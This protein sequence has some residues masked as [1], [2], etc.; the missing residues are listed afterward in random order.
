[1]KA[2]R[3]WRA[4]AGAGL[5]AAGM[6]LVL[7]MPREETHTFRVDAGGCRL[8]TDIVEPA[9]GTPRGYVVLYH[10]LSANKRIMS[11]WT[12]GFA[13][14][15]LRVFVPDLPGHGRMDGPF[16]FAWADEC[17]A[18]LLRELIAR[19]L[20]DP[21]KTILAGHSMGGAIALRV[22]ER[23][24]VAGV[25]AISPAPMRPE[26][27]IPAEAIPYH[28][29]GRLPAHSLLL[30]G[31]WETAWMETAAKDLIAS[32]DDGSS[33]YLRI[34]YA[35]HVSLLFDS[36][37]VAAAEDWV[38]GVLHVDAPQ[39]LPPHRGVLG[40]FLGL[41]GIVTLAGPFLHEL[42]Q[43]K[44]RAELPVE[45][46]VGVSKPRAFVVVGIIAAG[47]V[48]VLHD[49]IPL[50]VLRSFEG[51]YFASLLLL[52]GFFALAVNARRL[53]EAAQAS[54]NARASGRP[55]YVSMLLAVFAALLLGV[56][57]G[58]WLDLSVTEVWP[59]AGRLARLLPFAAAVLPYHFAEEFLLGPVREGKT[60]ARLMTALLLRLLIWVLLVAGIFVLHSGEILP[61]LLAP[62]LGLFCLGQRWAMDVVRKDTAS[63]A[64]SALFGAILLAG[65]CLVAFP[66]T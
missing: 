49:W 38:R 65:F 21:E 5:C 44:K 50:R 8:I 59:T 36:T 25:V 66:T 14:Q 35:T 42:M 27:G 60:A 45:S 11:Y 3:M 54:K 58:A 34:P 16:S 39:K 19:G 26:R 12:D 17:G 61:V 1:M 52:I 29:F 62:Y 2:K 56:L 47:S 57:F 53:R 20:L 18:N 4:V 33:K 64:A 40:F 55:Q 41:V 10:G 9:G 46:G 7:A 15:G 13:S 23:M 30:S 6:A 48:A 43:D 63:P 24:P 37:A 28:D 51:D 31:A 32:A 22:A